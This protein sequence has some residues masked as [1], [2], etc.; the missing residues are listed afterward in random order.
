[1]YKQLLRVSAIRTARRRHARTHDIG[2][3]GGASQL[4]KLG[5]AAERKRTNRL[6]RFDADLPRDSDREREGKR[7]ALAEF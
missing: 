5:A 4:V 2:G 1:V 7:R 6:F 3:R